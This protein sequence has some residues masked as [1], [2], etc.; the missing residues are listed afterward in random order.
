MS[1]RP[2]HDAYW[3]AFWKVWLPLFA[4]ITAAFLASGGELLSVYGLALLVGLNVLALGLLLA[5][6][7]PGFRRALE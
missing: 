1:G 4:L 7:R 3:R 6:R 5:L 2:L